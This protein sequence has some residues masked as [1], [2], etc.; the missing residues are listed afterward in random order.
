MF[1]WNLRKE[2]NTEN[3]SHIN[4]DWSESTKLSIFR[5]GSSNIAI[6]YISDLCFLGPPICMGTLTLLV[7][8]D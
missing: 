1:A 2:A 6:S 4:S 8:T 7:I 5:K 3:H